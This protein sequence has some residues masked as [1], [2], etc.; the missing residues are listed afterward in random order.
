M[1]RK[2]YTVEQIIV[3]LR[4]VEVLC[5]Q[6]MTAKEAVKQEGITENTY[7]RWR[8]EY[9]GMSTSDVKRLKELEKENSRLKKIVAD[10]SL[11]NEMLK[12]IASKKLLSPVK[13]QMTVDYLREEYEVSERRACRALDVNRNTY[14]YEPKEL[15]DE[16]DMHKLII[17]MATNFG[18]VGYRMVAD[19]LRNQGIL[20]NPKR[21][22]RIW[23]EEGLKLPAKQTKQ[24]RIVMND[25][26][27]IRLRPEHKNHVWSYD[28]VEDKTMDGRKVRW[29]NIIDEHE[30]ECLASIPRR[31]WRNSD[32]ISALSEI[33]ILRGSPE[34]IRSDNG[35]EFIAKKLRKW[36]S[37]IGVITTYIE[38]GS[39]WE[40]GYVESFN[41]RMRDEFLNGEL[42]GNLY[43]AK[44][45]TNR[46]VRYYNTIRPHSSLGGKTPAP[47]TYTFDD[48]EMTEALRKSVWNVMLVSDEKRKAS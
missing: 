23:R 11:D 41:A 31:S 4:K 6:G 48:M 43:E 25:G 39:P 24:R 19:M 12:D 3:I 18:R 37:D 16:D 1:A 30:H 44:V 36:L 14:R 20:I 9:G 34:Y 35:P 22:E 42:F 33:M 26:S 32:V 8:R 27:C 2:N 21:V 7:F 28:F 46:W 38:P 29:L 17:Y 10:L 5:G 47:Q 13:R 40:N 45:L 15:P